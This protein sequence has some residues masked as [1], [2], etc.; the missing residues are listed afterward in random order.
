MKKKTGEM[1]PTANIV[2]MLLLSSFDQFAKSSIVIE[3]PTIV[4]DELL[5]A[6]DAPNVYIRSA[7]ESLTKFGIL[8][9]THIPHY[10]SARRKSLRGLAECLHAES[11]TPV[12]TMR[13][14]LERRS[15]GAA[16]SRG[17]PGD[18]RSYC[19]KNSW[20][21]RDIIDATTKHLFRSLD[22]LSNRQFSFYESND[23]FTMKPYITYE[24]LI[25]NGEH[26][27]H[28]HAYYA[29][30]TS[31][32]PNRTFGASKVLSTIDF[33]TDGG[34]FI[35]MTAGYYENSPAS[36]HTSSHAGLYVKLADGSVARANIDDDALVIMVGEAGA[37]WLS[38]KLGSALRAVPHAMVA[39]LSN[40]G[41][42]RAW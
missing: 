30:N 8:Q 19:G 12:M 6:R 2:L 18:F 1:F 40:E 11:N 29:A 14:R 5:S 31:S 27:E 15:T 17:I 9:I 13:D 25:H 23:E 33:H 41:C 26:I 32:S 21:L 42:T 16:S 38:P 37:R 20:E 10:T 22:Q 39:G 35:A 24:D 3:I 7:G 4:F 36:E 28:L 34:L